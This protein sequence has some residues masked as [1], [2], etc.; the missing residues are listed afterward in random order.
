MTLLAD[1]LFVS[2]CI[3]GFII[4]VKELNPFS[5]SVGGERHM[6][7]L[8]FFPFE[9]LFPFPFPCIYEI[10]T[11]YSALWENAYRRQDN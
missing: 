3:L 7:A 9:S 4:R 6:K 5:T 8:L 10:P 2:L 1:L 11:I